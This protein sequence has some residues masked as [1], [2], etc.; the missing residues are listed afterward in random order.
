MEATM[1]VAAAKTDRGKGLYKASEQLQPRRI[2]DAQLLKIER[3][4]RRGGAK[5]RDREDFPYADSVKSPFPGSS[6]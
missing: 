6:G 5:S 2:C 1:M 3:S 4:D